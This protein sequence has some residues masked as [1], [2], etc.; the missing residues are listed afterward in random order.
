MELDEYSRLWDGSDSGWTLVQID[1]IIWEVTFLFGETGPTKA[2]II[3][4]KKVIPE[5]ENK[6]IVELFKLLKRKDNYTVEERFGN[7]QSRQIG[8]MATEL[9]LEFELKSMDLGGYFP[10]KENQIFIIEDNDIRQA[11]VEKMIAAGV[12][13]E[14]VHID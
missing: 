4:L 11:V 14:Q 6:S 12:E 10:Y 13:I 5:F 9:K 8:Q 3:A 7:I 2:E 1:N